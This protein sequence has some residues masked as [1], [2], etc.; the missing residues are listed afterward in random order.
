MK[1]ILN[2]TFGACF[3]TIGRF[4]AIFIVGLLL[5]FIGS[6]LGFKLDSIL[7]IRVNASTTDRWA[8]NLPNVTDARWFNC[9]GS[10]K[11]DTQ[12]SST[13]ISVNG[14]SYIA[15]DT[16][17]TI[18]NNG[19]LIGTFSPITLK[20]GYLYGISMYICSNKNLANSTHEMY[21]T[22]YSNRGTNDSTYSSTGRGF[23]SN[24]PFVIGSQVGSY[25]YVYQGTIVP[26]IDNSWVFL[27]LK[28]SSSI[29]G[30][31]PAI[32]SMTVEGIG[33]YEDV[34]ENAVKNATGNLETSINQ[35]TDAVKDTN[36]TIK[37]DDISGANNSASGFF[38]NF[39]DNDFGLS[40]ILTAPLRAINAMLNDSCVAPGATYKGQ[41]FS[42]PCGS[43]LWSRE[44]G[45][46]FRNFLNIFY[47]GFLAYFVIRS[48]F[49]DIE[50][51]KNPNNDKVEVEKL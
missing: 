51:L 37:N 26:K 45:S 12:L 3:R 20:S 14:R 24:E 21:S 44:G 10:N 38:D 41:S 50:K 25:C 11:C 8:L 22:I 42:L 19:I 1:K 48:L 5:I 46:D 27:R 43:M 18:A 35:T 39:E 15:G 16:T 34:I 40:S 7:P 23:L 13:T 6:K 30:F 9:T 17:G 33:V 49:L 4:L 29:T 28:S 31:T 32:V 36:D 2:W 47:G